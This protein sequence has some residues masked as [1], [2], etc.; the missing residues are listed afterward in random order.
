MFATLWLYSVV[1]TAVIWLY[2]AIQE[3]RR[4]QF[5][6]LIKTERWQNQH[7]ELVLRHLSPD[8]DGTTRLSKD[9]FTDQLLRRDGYLGLRAAFLAS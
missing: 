2:S 6:G 7:L 8:A 9:A 5:L 4:R 1:L 3:D